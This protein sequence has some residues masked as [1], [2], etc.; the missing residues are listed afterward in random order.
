MCYMHQTDASGRRDHDEILINFF[1]QTDAETG[2]LLKL[3][4]RR[5]KGM[6]T[7]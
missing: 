2:K 6:S 1:C 4:S 3:N 5:D 7:G